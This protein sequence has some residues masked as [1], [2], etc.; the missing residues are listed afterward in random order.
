MSIQS[1][2][3]GHSAP[4]SVCGFFCLLILSACSDSI[5]SQGDSSPDDTPA[6]WQLF[7]QTLPVAVEAVNRF[8]PSVVTVDV[9]LIGPDGQRKT[10]PAF[11]YDGFTRSQSSDRSEVLT[12]D[13]SRE[14]RF[15][16]TPTAPGDWRWLRVTAAGEE[17]GEWASFYVAPN[18]DPERHGFLRI[19]DDSMHLEF[20]DGTPFFAVGENVAWADHRG[21]GAYEDWIAKLAASGANYIRAW[22]PEWD[23]GLLYEPATLEDWSARMDRA[24]RLDRVMELAKQNDMQV[25]LSLQSHFPFEL[26]GQFG[27]GWDTN[28]FNAANGGPLVTPDEVFTLPLEADGHWAGEWI[29]PWSG[30]TLAVVDVQAEGTLELAVPSF[31][32]DAALRL[33][34][35]KE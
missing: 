32:R 34:L 17:A 28:P 31:S 18:T 9:E 1:I 3:A 24:W 2:L 15:R 25:M 26:N 16:F 14:W 8:N 13:G 33:D 35:V 21:S 6:V 19:P 29:D 27:S 22:M 23:M 5:D 11:V 4:L 7:E 12:A 10:V 20:E 30:D